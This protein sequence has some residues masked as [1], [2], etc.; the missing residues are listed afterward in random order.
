LTA[1]DPQGVPVE[2]LILRC[3]MGRDP[4]VPGRWLAECIDLDLAAVGATPEAAEQSLREAVVGYIQQVLDTDEPSS[5][6]ALLRRRA[7][8]SQRARW[9]LLRLLARSSRP[10]DGPPP[11]SR[12]YEDVLPFQLASAR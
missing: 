1:S 2:R 12:S 11:W 9:H 7:P 4:E 6:P 5:V 10:N 3:L 8:W